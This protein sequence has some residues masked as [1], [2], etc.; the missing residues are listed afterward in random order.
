MSQAIDGAAR[1]RIHQ[2]ILDVLA[3]EAPGASS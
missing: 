1:Q 2:T 3:L